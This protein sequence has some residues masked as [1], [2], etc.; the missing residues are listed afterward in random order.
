M[1]RIAWDLEGSGID[2]IVVPS[3]TDVAG[4][5]IHMRPVAGLPLLH[6]EQPQAG[7]AGG[8]SKRAFDVVLTL[9]G[10][11]LLS[12]VLLAIAAVVKLQDGGPV[13][14]RQSRVGRDGDAFG[15]FKFRSMVVD[16]EQRLSEVRGANE[17]DSVLFKMKD[18]PRITKVGQFLRRYSVDELPQLFNV[19]RGEMSLVG[20]APAAAQRGEPVRR[21]RAP[22]AARPA[23]ASPASGRS[24][25]APTCSWDEAVR[26]DLY[27]VDNWSMTSDLV[28]L[29]KTVKAVIGK[30]GAY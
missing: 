1:R 19:L 18:D 28:I 17:M 7:E 21:R 30:S 27:Y 12:P 11:L 5:R 16:A 20:P 14:F 15:M 2:L 29:F 22:P 26:L 24:P 6:M 8:L 4:P 23:R 13:F 10:L 9:F 25:G 3:V